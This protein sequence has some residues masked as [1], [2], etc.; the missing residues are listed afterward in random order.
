MS[1][2]WRR[3]QM[4]KIKTDIFL[5]ILNRKLFSST[6]IS[7]LQCFRIRSSKTEITR[8]ESRNWLLDTNKS[9]VDFL[10]YLN[11][12]SLCRGEISEHV[13]SEICFFTLVYVF[14]RY[15]NFGSPIGNI[16]ISRNFIWFLR[17]FAD[18]W[19]D[20]YSAS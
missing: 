16:R 13:F 19:N 15:G 9:E 6:S 8:N 11:G 17:H 2:Q 14:R 1:T 5:R 20:K 4:K 12:F 10:K 7:Q 18:T 3:S